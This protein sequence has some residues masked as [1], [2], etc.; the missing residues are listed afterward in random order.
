VVIAYAAGSAA[1]ARAPPDSTVSTSVAATDV[2]V[3]VENVYVLATLLP[4]IVVF[5][6]SAK[7]LLFILL[8]R[9]VT[10]ATLKL[11]ST[12]LLLAS[13]VAVMVYAKFAV[14]ANRRPPLSN[15]LAPTDPVTVM[16]LCGRLVRVAS[17]FPPT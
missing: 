4:W 7:V 14:C 12:G 10:A 1:G 6:P 9:L 17:A 3:I 16:S 11:V 5:T 2:S 8:M 13:T 15:R